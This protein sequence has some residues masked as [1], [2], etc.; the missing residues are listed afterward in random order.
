MSLFVMHRGLIISIIQILFSIIYYFVAIPIYNGWLMLGYS[1]IYTMLPVFCLIF[2]EDVTE[3]K[4]MEYPE[5]YKTLQ[6]SREL[7]FKAFLIMIWKSI[8]QG[9]FII[10]VAFNIF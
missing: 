4:T 7:N 9:T 6:K 5:L 1:T 2:D 8:F 10:I 3:D